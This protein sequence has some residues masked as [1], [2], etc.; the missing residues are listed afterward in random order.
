MDEGE[1]ERG[2]NLLCWVMITG[3]CWG[4]WFDAQSGLTLLHDKTLANPRLNPA[5]AGLDHCVL[6]SWC[7]GDLNC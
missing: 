4:D 7:K 1:R 2:I 5:G 6:D 3:Q